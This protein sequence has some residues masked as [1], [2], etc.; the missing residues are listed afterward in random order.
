M[1]QK[2][3]KSSF[4]RTKLAEL[5]LMDVFRDFYK[6][7]EPDNVGNEN[8]VFQHAEM[9]HSCNDMFLCGSNESQFTFQAALT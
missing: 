2:R 1:I 4:T 9:N 7:R 8:N 5:S 3:Y 6:R